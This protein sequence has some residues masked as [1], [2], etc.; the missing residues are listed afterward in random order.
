MILMQLSKK[1]QTVVMLSAIAVIIIL[2][3]SS[4]TNILFQSTDDYGTGLTINTKA[5]KTF[6]PSS[7]WMSGQGLPTN[8]L[9]VVNTKDN[10]NDPG[11]IFDSSRYIV[12]WQ[13]NQESQEITAKVDFKFTTRYTQ[14]LAIFNYL[15]GVFVPLN[16][17]EAGFRNNYW[18]DVTFTDINGV[19]TRIIDG[20]N[21]STSTNAVNKDFVSLI[22]G[23]PNR[24][25]ATVGIVEETL[26][27]KN[28]TKNWWCPPDT[29]AATETMDI[30]T[31][32]LVFKIKGNHIGTINIKCYVADVIYATSETN[33]VYAAW[34]NYK[35]TGPILLSEDNAYLASGTGVVEIESLN[36]IPDS[37]PVWE[38]AGGTGVKYM[39]YT[40]AEGQNVTFNVKTGYSGIS[41]ES[42][43]AG[44]KAG[45]YITISNSKGERVKTGNIKFYENGAYKTKSLSSYS[46]GLIPLADGLTNYRIQ[47]QIP[48]GAFIPNDPNSNE[49]MVTLS[50]TLFAQSEQRLFVV[51]N[52]SKI[53]GQAKAVFD[54]NQYKQW[55][56]CILKLSAKPNPSGANNV[57]YFKVWVTYDGWT[58]TNYAMTEVLAPAILG[59]D[60][61]YTATVS[62]K[63]S[64]G[65]K[66]LYATTVAVDSESR[67]GPEG[68]DQAYVEQ[69]I[70]GEGIFSGIDANTLYIALAVIIIICA[71]G[72]GLYI[73]QKRGRKK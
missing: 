32:T 9:N 19:S 25:F 59:S 12:S 13:Q 61:V 47:Y 39:K 7:S 5:T 31:D 30:E 1:S 34:L 18:W 17:P 40:W 44:Y 15:V 11:E 51:D 24:G 49:W 52:L 26:A 28:G 56:T 73:Y 64:L 41:L 35:K 71:L 20:R 46:N 58:S 63:V 57:D 33:V 48:A 66:N 68:Q 37:V 3:M 50:N 22:R 14:L 45:W 36:R 16:F 38:T 65:D 70:P 21:L 10:I 29:S 2:L 55:D 62:F 67:A 53:P 27:D 43:Q 42:D 8:F 4:N 69:V 6:L 23:S 72:A 54:K 60:G